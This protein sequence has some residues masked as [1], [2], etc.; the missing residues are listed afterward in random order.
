[1]LV[2]VEFDS[3]FSVQPQLFANDTTGDAVSGPAPS[4][5]PTDPPPAYHHGS[6]PTSGL[7]NLAG[8]YIRQY[9]PAA[10]AAGAALL[11]PMNGR[12]P[13]V[14]AAPNAAASSRA[15]QMRSLGVGAEQNVASASASG[16]SSTLTRVEARRRRAELE[17]Q[18]AA[19]EPDSSTS[20]FP[21]SPSSHSTRSASSSVPLS[22]TTQASQRIFHP[23][24]ASAGPYPTSLSAAQNDSGVPRDPVA[25]RI[26][27]S[28]VG[29]YGFEEIRKE[30]LGDYPPVVAAAMQ[31]PSLSTAS[32]GGSWW[33]WGAGQPTGAEEQEKKDA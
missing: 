32:P 9:G 5:A 4:Q 25:A 21:S 29:G 7:Y 33:R 28:F 19:L 14:R 13:S 6:S 3:P 12:A 1:M 20:S 24:S 27:R 15:D 26:E 30:E 17:A 10:V 11:Q 22:A 31:R 18:L 16:M 8:N 23:R 2:C